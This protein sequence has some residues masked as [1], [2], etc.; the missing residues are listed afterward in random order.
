M[1]AKIGHIEFPATEI[2]KS[3]NQSK[4]SCNMNWVRNAKNKVERSIFFQLGINLRVGFTAKS[5]S[6][7]T[8]CPNGL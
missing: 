6:T 1:P 8:I 4:A 7:I 2:G 3:R 5:V